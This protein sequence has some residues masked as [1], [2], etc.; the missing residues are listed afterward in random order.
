ANLDL[1]EAHL[2]QGLEET[3]LSM[4]VHRV[5]ER[6]VAV[7]QVDA[8]PDRSLGDRGVRPAPVG[9]RNRREG[10]VLLSWHSLHLA[11]W[12]LL[13]M[14]PRNERP[15]GSKRHRRSCEPPPSGARSGKE[16]V[17]SRSQH[18]HGGPQWCLE[19]AQL[20]SCRPPNNSRV[21]W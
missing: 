14:D 18:R 16:Q 12:S 15:P 8:A 11:L 13:W 2:D 7:A 3:P 9:Q 5:D 4:D 10:P 1:L 20:S 6:L 21:L 19:S 17:G